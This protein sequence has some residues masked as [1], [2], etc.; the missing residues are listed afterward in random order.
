VVKDSKRYGEP[1]I[2][3]WNELKM[4]MRK[5]HVP[6]SYH[7]KLLSKLQDLTQDSNS[8]DQY[9]RELEIALIRANIHEN[10][11]AFIV[12]FLNG[13]NRDICGWV[14]CHAYLNLQDLFHHAIKVEQ[15]LRRKGQ[16]DY[17]DKSYSFHLLSGKIIKRVRALGLGLKILKK[18]N[19]KTLRTIRRP[20]LLFLLPTPKKES[21]IKCFK[22]LGRGHIASQC[23]TKKTMILKDNGSISSLGSSS[24]FHSSSSSSFSDNDI[25]IV[26]FALEGDLLV[27]RRLLGS[28][29]NKGEET[30]RENIF[31]T[32]CLINGHACSLIIA[33]GSCNTLI[34]I[35]KL[36]IVTTSLISIKE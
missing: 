26:E 12:R 3:T 29:A 27:L 19:I 17:H 21:N 30:Q 7:S 6:S 5:R 28:L 1:P 35:L 34:S 36:I 13:L 11:D 2:S 10:E 9:H 32:R 8:V 18:I 22:S 31:H 25:E 16:Y 4:L 33:S 23:P 15:Q 14:E 20:I 24:F